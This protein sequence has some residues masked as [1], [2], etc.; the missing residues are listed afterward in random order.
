[1]GSL[2]VPHLLQTQT[3]D[4]IDFGNGLEWILLIELEVANVGKHGVVFFPGVTREHASFRE[5][6]YRPVHSGPNSSIV[7]LQH[8]LFPL[9]IQ[10][11]EREINVVVANPNRN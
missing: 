11:C 8:F 7:L 5:L 1:M 4:V 9:S 6:I 10:V 3:V 2:V